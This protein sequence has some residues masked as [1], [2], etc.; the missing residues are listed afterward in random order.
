MLEG[1]HERRTSA[2]VSDGVADGSTVRGEVAG[3]GDGPGADAVWVEGGG[4]QRRARL[5]ELRGGGRRTVRA[6]V[7]AEG[8]GKDGAALE[9]TLGDTL[10]GVHLLDVALEE[11]LALLLDGRGALGLLR[12]GELGTLDAR[13]RLLARL[14]RALLDGRLV[15]VER[16]LRRTAD[17]VTGCGVEM[18]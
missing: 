15:G 6:A 17:E 2:E 4:H 12:G 1:L 8:A 10:A 14:V 9:V 18:E 13:R 5:F 11:A 3:R 7:T 16:G